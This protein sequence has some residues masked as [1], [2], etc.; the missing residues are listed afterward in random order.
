MKFLRGSFVCETTHGPALAPEA[1]SPIKPTK[2][3]LALYAGTTLAGLV[4]VSAGHGRPEN[5]CRRRPQWREGT[6]A[7][8]QHIRMEHAAARAT[9]H[10]KD[11]I[12][13]SENKVAGA[14]NKTSD[15]Y[16]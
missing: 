4:V 3:G 8:S 9:G 12:K 1:P 14:V 11:A 10:A 6:N 16:S 5:A 13:K 2:W 15:I 7:C